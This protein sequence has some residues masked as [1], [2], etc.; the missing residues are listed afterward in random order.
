ME[1]PERTFSIGQ[2]AARTGLTRRALRVYEK[3]GLLIPH[4]AA[5]GYRRY[6][7]QHVK[8]ALIIHDMRQAGLS[9]AIIQQMIAIKRMSGSAQEKLSGILVMLNQIQA[10]LIAKRQAMDAVLLQVEG[11]QQQTVAMLAALSEP[12]KETP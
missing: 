3:T 2:L 5:N 10:D 1:T 6:T 9:L 7:E 11:Y 4:R 12:E 8:D